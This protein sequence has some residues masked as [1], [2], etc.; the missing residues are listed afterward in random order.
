M[1]QK[2]KETY[3]IPLILALFSFMLSL[4]IKNFILSFSVLLFGLLNGW[5]A[6]IGK[7][8]NYVFGSI[9]TLLNA[10]V[11]WKANLYGIAILSLILYFPLQIQGLFEWYLLKN[12]DS[13]VNIRSFDTKTS[14]LITI[15]CFAGSIGLGFILSRIP[16]QQL[17]FLDATSNAIN[18]CA[19]VLMN[20]RFRE[21]WWI[22][23][24]NNIADL[25]IWII[26]F[27]NK[28][29]NSLTMLIVSI[30][31]LVLNVVALIKWE[32]QKKDK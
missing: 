15:S 21:C 6:A 11:S 14:I 9:F 18:I 26:G 5:Y 12:K 16:G 4:S 24:G 30:S 31:N 22:L 28:V 23:L 13:K 19:I 1:R 8:Y 25:T 32:K 2:T 17:A 27:I 10:Y 29:P 3:I 20:L 7:W